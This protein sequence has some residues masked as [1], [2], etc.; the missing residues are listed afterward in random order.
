LFLDSSEQQTKCLRLLGGDV[1]C[2]RSLFDQL[3]SL[4]EEVA[5]S[6]RG[7]P[8]FASSSEGSLPLFF[9]SL[10]V[11]EYGQPRPGGQ[12][13]PGYVG[14]SPKEEFHG[15]TCSC[16]QRC[17]GGH[18]RLLTSRATGT[19]DDTTT[20]GAVGRR[21]VR[22]AVF[23]R[24]KGSAKSEFGATCSFPRSE[25]CKN[26]IAMLRRTRTNGEASVCTHIEAGIPR[27]EQAI[28]RHLPARSP[29][30]FGWR[31][32]FRCQSPR[33]TRAPCEADRSRPKGT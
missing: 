24:P 1:T 14:R 6:A 3:S 8:P 26:R 23:S 2:I 7:S 22:R 12:E 27:R 9:R 32:C 16:W 21:L 5:T 30:G 4:R 31:R 33:P 11:A 17:A 19:G 13:L 10:G 15:R 28:A 20:L 25:N 29:R 18:L